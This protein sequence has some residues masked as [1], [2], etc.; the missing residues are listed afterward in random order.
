MQGDTHQV[1]G[2]MVQ[3]AK[4]VSDRELATRLRNAGFAARF[5]DG[6][7]GDADDDGT[8]TDGFMVLMTEAFAE[9]VEV[10][11]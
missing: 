4:G 11:S 10:H 9:I 8:N 2:A 5:H 7:G 6:D 1:L 3:P